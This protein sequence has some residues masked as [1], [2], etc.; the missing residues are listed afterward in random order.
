M[1]R[2]IFPLSEATRETFEDNV[3]AI[4]AG[5]NKCKTH[6]YNIL[7]G[8]VAD[9]FPPFYSAYCGTLKGG[10]STSHWDADLEY[11]RERFMRHLPPADL[12]A[13]VSALLKKQNRTIERYFEAVEDGDLSAAEID[14]MERLLIAERDAIGKT[15]HALKLKRE[16]LENGMKLRTVR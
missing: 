5:W 4:C 8:T 16:Q 1:P 12:A 10:V 7:D 6:V 2:E 11:A 3:K 13:S 9:P 15:L 14:A